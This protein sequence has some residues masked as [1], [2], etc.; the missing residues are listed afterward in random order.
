[1]DDTHKRK[2]MIMR[3]SDPPFIRWMDLIHPSNLK[4]LIPLSH[5][6]PAS[7]ALSNSPYGKSALLAY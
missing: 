6:V 3:T 4:K 7:F 1:M 5:L 2:K